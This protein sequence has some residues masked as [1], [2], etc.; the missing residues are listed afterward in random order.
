VKDTKSFLIGMLSVGLVGTWVYHLY[1]KT[2][3]SQRRTEVYVKDSTAV[4]QG[5]QDSLQKIYSHTINDLDAR[6]DSTKSSAGMLQG[7]WKNK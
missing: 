3:Y 6:L 2:Q 7:E 4:A 5:V 1:D